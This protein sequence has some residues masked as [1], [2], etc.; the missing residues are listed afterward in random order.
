MLHHSRRRFRTSP[1]PPGQTRVRF[2]IVILA[3][4]CSL[5]EVFGAPAKRW[6]AQSPALQQN[7]EI[8]TLA[9]DI[10]S[11]Q[12]ADG[13]AIHRYR[14]SVAAGQYLR[15]VVDQRGVDVAVTLLAPNERQIMTADGPSGAWGPEPLSVIVERTGEY[16]V[17]VR[18]PD[19]K[20][21]TGSY[22][23]RIE[24]LRFPTQAD[25]DRVVA[26]QLFWEAYQLFK[27]P[28][29]EARRKALEKYQ[30]ALPMFRA[31][32]DRR[33]EYYSSVVV[34]F[35]Y[36]ASGESQT[37]LE[38]YRQALALC[39]ALE[40]TTDE[41]VLLNNLGGVYDTL[42]E[43]H[44]ALAF[45]SDALALWS[46]KNER[47]PQADTLNNI[48]LIHF[49]LGEPQ[50]ALDFYN[51]SLTLKKLIGN[52]AK[53]ANT[54]G[55]I[56]LVYATLGE[57]GRALEYLTEALEFQH[58]AKDLNGEA[59]THY[60]MAY[61][62]ASLG[63][64]KKA[65]EHYNL[66]LPLQRT[67]GNRRGE[68]LTLDSLGV[69]YNSLGQ[70]Q[71]ALESHQQALLLQRAT[72]D[73]RSEAATLE[74]IGYLQFLSGE[75][76]PAAQYYDDALALSQ[77]VGDRREEANI[78]QGI[79]RLERARSN[80]PAARKRI[81]EAIVKIE[82]V[83]GQTDTQLR[84]SYLGVKHDA[85]QF[86]IDLLMQMHRLNPS[87]GNDA[88][89]L[90]V[91]E[92]AHARSLLEML[93][94]ARANIRQGVNV[95]LL[96]REQAL[97]QQLNAK[98]ERLMQALAQNSKERAAALNKE[99]SA[100]EDQYQQAQSA[101][102]KASPGYAALTQ[103]QPLGLKEIQSELD[104]GTLLLEYSLGEER[105]YVWAVTA[106]SLRTYELPG[107][108][109]IEQAA[110]LVY[111][112]LTARTQSI[113]A[114]SPRLKRARLT[115]T[116]AQLLHASKE[117][118]ALVLGPLETELGL[119]RLVVVADGA[120]QYIPFAA[121]P[122]P[123]KSS[124]GKLLLQTH[125]IISLPSASSLAI[126]RAGLRNRI[127]AP[128]AVAV[129]A[130]PVFSATDE[131]LKAHTQSGPPKQAP[132]ATSAST[133]II[134]HVAAG[135]GLTIRRLRFTRREAEQIL[136]E[137]PS[138][139]NLKAIDF[140]ANRAT[141]TG[142]ELSKYR[143]VHFATHGYV[144]SQRS[145]L[146]AIVL[147]LVDEDGQP[148]DGFLRAHEI[149]NLNLPAELVVLSACETG[150]GKEIKGEGLV[151]LTQG[152]MY[153]GARRVV[154]S[155]WNVNDKATAELMARF[156]RGMLKE[157]KTPAAA[158]RSAQMEMSRQPQWQS[159]Y[160]WAAFTLQGDWR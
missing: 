8:T 58:Q 47:G 44:Q 154:V 13:N 94:E 124:T 40:I 96:E 63:D 21:P 81:E 27:Q 126:Q 79:A 83:R 138:G 120:L 117:L 28:A 98:A 48:G 158:L 29:I 115:Q 16:Y 141:A 134:E 137:A 76:V 41:P 122:V 39:R 20:P 160:Y 3:L 10:P 59:G 50:L 45:Y 7:P 42:G 146:S 52:P 90:R 25:K 4:G 51:Q 72:K 136:A 155:L 26:E 77:A 12:Y 105:S 111:E 65:L 102:R 97:A 24:A 75:F 68:G 70:R 14:V 32:N 140:K 156:Y 22:V 119:S 132:G 34:A 49:R 88:A 31:A 1:W 107:R 73:R 93:T 18:L 85:Y 148:Q 56:A 74:H 9:L 131:R 103:P 91:S 80:F 159:P 104:P 11:E 89:A 95:S 114:E 6:S 54:L 113:A 112:L 23:I 157:N 116:D 147:S 128:N 110:R 82:A 69:T 145:D 92:E 144:D 121:L 143:Y 36:L 5:C 86:Y 53:I 129:I 71:Q 149:Y 64:M 152:F 55:N 87:S 130:D 118:S 127:P 19:K 46:A 125:E 123:G 62:H 150:L 17:E 133:R 135:S 84:A 38:Y 43:P 61:V 66:A 67:A 108:A 100:L 142:G 78:L 15:V 37:A 153:A 151:G 99:I 109:Q 2:V 35:I 30:Q 60:S 139:K 101:I 33:M 106:N 57:P